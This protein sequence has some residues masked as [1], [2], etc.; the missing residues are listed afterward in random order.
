MAKKRSTKPFISQAAQE[1]IT[2]IVDEV[3][4]KTKQII[5]QMAEQEADF[6]KRRAGVREKIER[7][8]RKTNGRI[9]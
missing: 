8:A 4:R 5:E 1:Q 2:G 9:V 3:V 6:Q 7:G